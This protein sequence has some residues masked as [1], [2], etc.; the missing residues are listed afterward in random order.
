MVAFTCSGSSGQAATSRTSCGSEEV[1]LAETAPDSA[2]LFRAT[3]SFSAV[4]RGWSSPTRGGMLHVVWFAALILIASSVVLIGEWSVRI[5]LAAMLVWLYSRTGEFERML[6]PMSSR[7]WPLR[8]TRSRRRWSR[9][10]PPRS[11]GE[12][13]QLGRYRLRCRQVWRP[14]RLARALNPPTPFKTSARNVP[15]EARKLRRIT[16]FCDQP[17]E[18]LQSGY[19]PVQCEKLQCFW[20]DSA[21]SKGRS[22]RWGSQVQVL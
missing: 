22:T 16:P 4:S 3:P 1:K 20:A 10:Y 12:A 2:P 7:N 8:R 18:V 14:N 17:C 15:R 6:D 11:S 13:K 9:K 19:R 5:A 21:Y